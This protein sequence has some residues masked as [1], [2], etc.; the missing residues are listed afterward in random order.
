MKFRKHFAQQFEAQWGAE[1]FALVAE[2]GIDHGQIA[3][4]SAQQARD[5]AEAAQ[6]QGDWLAESFITVTH[7]NK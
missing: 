4:A 6:R 2:R 3:Q 7:Q 1:P 5:R